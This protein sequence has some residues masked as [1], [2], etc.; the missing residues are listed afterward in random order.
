MP[1]HWL[2][3]ELPRTQVSNK[4]K[5][6]ETLQNLGTVCFCGLQRQPASGAQCL[7]TVWSQQEAG[8]PLNLL[9]GQWRQIGWWLDDAFF[10]ET[11]DSRS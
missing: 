4:P 10:M 6:R 9:G 1:A 5:G 8:V 3:M 11:V 2:V 7:G